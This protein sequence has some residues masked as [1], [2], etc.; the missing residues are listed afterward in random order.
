MLVCCFSWLQHP[1]EMIENK[2]IK[3]HRMTLSLKQQKLLLV[4]VCLIS[5]LLVLFLYNFIQMTASYD[6]NNQTNSV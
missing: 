4:Y 6:D 5:A 2:L 1:W 3:L